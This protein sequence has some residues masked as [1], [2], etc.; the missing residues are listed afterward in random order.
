MLQSAR[1][2]RA[3][4]YFLLTL[5]I[6]IAFAAL[7]WILP[8]KAQ[9]AGPTASKYSGIDHD[10]SR[11]PAPYDTVPLSAESPQSDPDPSSNVVPQHLSD[12]VVEY[13]MKV[14]YDEKE[15]MLHGKQTV[16][17]KNPGAK[18]V[19]EIPFHLYP[20]A[21][22]SMNTTFNKESG[23]KLREDQRKKNDTGWMNILAIRTVDG[24]DL[25]G[26]L[27][28][29]QPDDGNKHDKTLG[30]LRL[31]DPVEPGA[32]VTLNLEFEVKLP[33]VYARMGYADDFVMAGQWFPKIAAYEPKHRR[34]RADEGWNLH[35]YHGNSEFY[36]D[37]GIYSVQIDV[38]ADYIVAATG[39]P[40]GAPKV[41]DSRKTYTFYADDVHD[42]AWSASPHF[43]YVEEA[44]ATAHI[45]GMKI[46][47]YLDPAHEKLKNRYIA[48]AKKSLAAYAE[49]FGTYPYSTL[50]IVVPPEDAS[51]A[52][53][54][55]YPT[56]ITAWAASEAVPDLS[57]E[58]VVAHEVAHQYWYGMVATNEFE[59]A[60]LD[61]GLTS[62]AED[63]FMALEYGLV[64]PRLLESSFIT[65]PAPLTQH[66]WAYAD[67][68]QYAENVYTRAKL[69]LVD[70]EQNIGEKQM[71]NV[72]KTYFE[73][74][75]FKHPS[76][77]QFQQVLETVTGKSW[78][79]YFDQYVYNGMMADYAV[80]SIAVESI[81]LDGR[82]AFEQ[83][84]VI[85]AL[86]GGSHKMVPIRFFFEDGTAQEHRW[87]GN[88]GRI[89]F[90]LTSSVPLHSVLIDP[91]YSIVLENRHI[92]NYYK[93][94]IDEKQKVRMNIGIT[95]IIETLIG[96][97]AW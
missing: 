95:K 61:E 23:G 91:D 17:W 4:I 36:A 50:S 35:Q 89:E 74:W 76:S 79:E 11:P 67:H 6:L 87:D 39:F 5:C 21:F 52:G 24:D 7:L 54:M 85:T 64:P 32:K 63:K 26:R 19:R 22:E 77:K 81:E 55:E 60:W 12:H 68:H 46:K 10:A 73:Q 53:G 70:I 37:F 20:N 28:F 62:Y 84:V 48:A 80:E 9:P 38:P 30:M 83:R 8:Q 88:G 72:L 78:D 82:T 25:I 51:G 14:I 45:P 29:I 41:T 65:S 1:T 13:H 56:L 58:R 42:F 2:D 93:A 49:W 33:H 90:K 3:G 66:A 59:E 34:G 44:F 94:S 15:Q 96:W 16:T 43:I 18:A 92:N 40:I 86:G 47:L 97:V 75:R 27:Q 57:L 31:H 69:V 71:L